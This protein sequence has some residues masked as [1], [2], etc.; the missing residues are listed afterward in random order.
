MKKSK[1]FHLNS[2]FNHLILL[3]MLALLSACGG[4]G[5]GGAPADDS[6]TSSSVS[7]VQL[8]GTASKGILNGGVVTAEELDSSGNA[9]ATLATTT[10]AADGSYSLTLSD[11]YTGGPVQV[12]ISVD[13]NTQMKCDSPVGCGTRTD[14]LT[15]T[16]SPLT[17]DFGEWYKPA[18]FTMTALV[19]DAEANATGQ[20]QHWILLLLLMLI[21]KFQIYWVA[22]IF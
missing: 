19:P 14:S 2:Y 15:D 13:A 3:L 18:S 1:T 17:I 20:R 4:G 21:Q 5:G 16:Y 12:S 11:D 10:T 8:N 7:G 6:S 22:L 9:I